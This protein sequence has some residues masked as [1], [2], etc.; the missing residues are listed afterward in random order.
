MEFQWILEYYSKDVIRVACRL[1]L[2]DGR[3][4]TLKLVAVVKCA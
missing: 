4:V 3:K 2:L 1:S